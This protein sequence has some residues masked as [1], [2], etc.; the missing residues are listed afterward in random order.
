M[1]SFGFS[2]LRHIPAPAGALLG[3][4]GSLPVLAAA[5][6]AASELAG[7]FA[8]SAGV[9][10]L[11]VERDPVVV[12]NRL[13]EAPLVQAHPVVS[14]ES[15]APDNLRLVGILADADA[16]HARAIIRRDGEAK[17]LVLGVGE[18][19]GE[20]WRIERIEA[21]AVLLSAGAVQQRLEL[22]I[23]PGAAPA[24]PNDPER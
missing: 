5:A 18:S 21:G 24:T 14:A 8:P 23:H 11:G 3:R 13:A 1:P 16:R 19:L 20:R 22:P 15:P 7:G 4:L 10:P 12:G 6:Y 9:P 2:F 17:P